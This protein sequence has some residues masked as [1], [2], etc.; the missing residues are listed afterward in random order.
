[1][2]DRASLQIL[3]VLQRDGRKTLQEL[4][5]KVG[6]SP[7]PCWR[8]LKAL[9]EEKIIRGYAAIVDREKIGLH[10]CV[11]AHVTLARHAEG[12]VDQF[13]AAMRAL[14]EVIECYGTTG[15]A[16]YIIKVIVAD[17]QTYDR[18]LHDNVFK[19]TGVAQIK[20]NIALREVKY[21]TALPL[22]R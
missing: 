6:L 20:S 7:T 8:R 17:I 10:V 2:L 19:L 5:E 12:A 15:D 11:L 13:E 21:Q 22:G 18:F 9:E 14:P 4:A 16:D 3:R 1:M